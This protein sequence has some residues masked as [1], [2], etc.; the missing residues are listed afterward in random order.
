MQ[1]REPGKRGPRRLFWRGVALVAGG[2]TAL[3]A[4]TRLGYRAVLYP[5][6][7]RALD[8]APAG[9]S[10]RGFVLEDGTEVATLCYPAPRGGATVVFFHGN[11]E[12]ISDFVGLGRALGAHGLGFVAVEYRG[13]G[14]SAGAPSEPALYRDADAVLGALRAEGVGPLVLWGRSLGTG[15][16][17]EMALRGHGERLVLSAPFT[18]IPAVAARYLPIL[19][20]GWLLDDTFDNLGKAP[21]VAVPTLIVHGDRDGVVPYAMGAAI[22]GAIPGA[23]LVTVAGA[24]HNDV[25]ARGGPELLA[26]IARHLGGGTNAR[27]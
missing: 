8:A 24:G 3:A 27:E 21:R 9:A 5:A 1:R 19:P 17:V 15:V 11:G 16:A 7:R 13:Y 18:S 2:Y 12:T 23:N 4:A 10:L 6:P 20:L 25:F 14:A 26:T 22:A